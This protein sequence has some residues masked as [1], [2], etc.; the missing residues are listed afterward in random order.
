MHVILAD[1]QNAVRSTL[2]K[3]LERMGCRVTEAADGAAA[4]S[5][6]RMDPADILLTDIVM[7]NKEGLETVRE[8]R[9]EFPEVRIV[10]MSGAWG[11][12]GDPEMY[13][14]MA[15][16]LGAASVLAKPFSAAQLAEALGMQASSED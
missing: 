9:R 11:G 12:D 3:L 13:L 16:A 4:L 7:P 6:Q 15:K 2:R 8:F 1:D 5:A 14:K 10:A